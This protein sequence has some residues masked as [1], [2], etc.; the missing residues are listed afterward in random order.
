MPQQIMQELLV[1]FVH[2]T[3]NFT[4]KAMLNSYASLAII[5]V[6]FALME[7]QQAVYFARLMLTEL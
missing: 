4:L 1:H 3:I 6:Q 2:A 5:L 7:L